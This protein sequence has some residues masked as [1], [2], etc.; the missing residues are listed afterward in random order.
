MVIARAVQGQD[1]TWRRGTAVSGQAGEDRAAPAQ[2]D[3]RFLDTAV[4]R[5]TLGKKDEMKGKMKKE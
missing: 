3:V 4:E 2:S 1:R 5:A